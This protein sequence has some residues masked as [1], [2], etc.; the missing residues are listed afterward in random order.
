M[1]KLQVHEDL[2][3]KNPDC[4]SNIFISMQNISPDK[5]VDR[6]G[7]RIVRSR[8]LPSRHRTGSY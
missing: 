8:T 5:I 2:S 1:C 3:T 4:Y 6:D 7:K